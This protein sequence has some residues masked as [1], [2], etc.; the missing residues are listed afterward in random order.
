MERGAEM[1]SEVVRT[2][3]R[4]GRLV[5][6]LAAAVALAAVIAVAGLHSPGEAEAEMPPIAVEM[7]TERA[8]YTDRVSAQ[9]RFKFDGHGMQVVNLRDASHVAVAKV[10]IQPAAAFPWHTHPGPVLI[11]VVEGDFVYVLA[12]DCVERLYQAGEALIDAGGDNVHTAY[13]P[14]SENPTV[15]VATFLGVPAD[16]P[17]TIPVDGPE[18][19]DLPVSPSH[20][21]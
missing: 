16:G 19:P 5:V 11:T 7:L 18:C 15:V 12:N 10:T 3:A 6:G 9:I 1:L 21:H 8:E 17:L 4:T 14:S 20:S 13:N 2:R